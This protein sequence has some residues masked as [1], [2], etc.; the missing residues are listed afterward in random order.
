MSFG[1]AGTIKHRKVSAIADGGD[2]T[3]VRPQADWND[4]D[5]MAGGAAGHLVVRDPGRADGWSLVNAATL[6]R[7]NNTG[8]SLAANDVVA[9][10][11]D[12]DVVLDDTQTSLKRFLVALDTITNLSDGAFA[13][14]GIAT[15]KSQGV[16]TALNYLRKSATSKAV[17]DTGIAWSAT[18]GCPLGALGVALS[19]SAGGAATVMALWFGQTVGTDAGAIATGLIS[20]ARL[21]TGVADGTKVLKGDQT[22]GAGSPAIDRVTADTTVGNTITE[23][24]IYTKSLPGGTLGINGRLRLQ[25]KLKIQ[26]LSAAT[27]TLRLKY[28]ATTLISLVIPVTDGGGTPTSIPANTSWLVTA[29]LSG[30][31]ATSAQIGMLLSQ[32]D[33]TAFTAWTKFGTE[34]SQGRGTAVEDSTVAKT[35]TL[36]VQW[37]TATASDTL[38]M[39]SAILEQL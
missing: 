39:E 19:A 35:L 1:T 5:A 28:G 31:G 15:V 36:T 9:V 18:Q 7:R 21:G 6:N 3:L 25:A 24:T 26:S 17:E 14:A 33:L 11:A 29:L 16:V 13:A 30:D 4:S 20:A 34:K 38:T 27:L 12:P 23:T 22:W 32:I 37:S 8:A 2:T 10:G